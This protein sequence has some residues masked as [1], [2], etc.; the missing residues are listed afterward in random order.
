MSAAVNS[1]DELV[2]SWLGHSCFRIKW[3][4]VTVLTDP[5]PPETGYQIP[6]Q[7][8]DLVTISHGH[9]DHSYRPLVTGQPRFLDQ[10]GTYVQQG[11]KI[12][13]LPSWH[14]PRRVRGENIIFRLDGEKTALAHLGDLGEKPD[15]A[16]MEQLKDLD[17]LMI[18]VGGNFT[19]DAEAAYQ[20]C[21]ELKP[22]VIIPMHYKTR[23]L[24]FELEPV[25]KFLLKFPRVQKLPR[26]DINSIAESEPAVIVLDY[27]L[28][29][30]REEG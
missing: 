27:L 30:K 7:E 4:Q 26:F 3:G 28:T 6:K 9:W 5:A 17:V 2:I 10:V 23:H 18:P 15:A 29:S 22:R 19:M 20:L 25:E 1:K 8:A 24:S 12:S 21:C 16:V 11:I 13:A 14:D